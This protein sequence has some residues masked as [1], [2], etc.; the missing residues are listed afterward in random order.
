MVRLA[1]V[2]CLLIL[3]PLLVSC[4]QKGGLYIPQNHSERILALDL[5]AAASLNI[6]TLPNYNE[7]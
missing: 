6:N 2:S 5:H 7:R 3:I 1:Q 4:G